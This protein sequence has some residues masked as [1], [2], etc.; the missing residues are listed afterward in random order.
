MVEGS[1]LRAVGSNGSDRNPR[2]RNLRGLTETMGQP[3][4]FSFHLVCRP[5]NTFTKSLDLSEDRICCGGP[6]ERVCSAV[7]ILNVVIDFFDQLLH[8]AKGPAANGLLCDP[9]EPDLHLIEPGGI[10]RSEVYVEPWPCGEPTSNSQMFV[11]SVI[12]RDEVHLQVLRYILLNLPEKT[13]ILLVPVTRSTFRE[14]FAACRVQCSKQRCGSVASIIVS[15]SLH[16]TQ[17]QRQ[18]RLGAF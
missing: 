5:G 15:H 2:M 10:G 3:S 6:D 8:A 14:H 16:I 1:P 12:I 17:S 7:R 18:H 9:V 11:R 13:Q 4:I